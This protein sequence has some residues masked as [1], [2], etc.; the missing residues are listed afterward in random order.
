MDPNDQIRH[1]VLT[2]LDMADVEITAEELAFL[3]A[4]SDKLVFTPWQ[5]KVIDSLASKYAEYVA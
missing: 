2:K 1:E 3:E 4:N 5:R